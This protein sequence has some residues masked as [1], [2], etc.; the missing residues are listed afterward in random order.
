MSRAS[1]S[2]VLAGAQR[3][4]ASHCLKAIQIEFSFHHLLR[5]TTLLTFERNLPG[6]RIFRLASRSLRE[7]DPKHYLG[8]IYGYSNFIALRP[9]VAEKLKAII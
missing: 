1:S 7:I 9:D 3:L 2:E 5:G 6:Y 8:T 4:I